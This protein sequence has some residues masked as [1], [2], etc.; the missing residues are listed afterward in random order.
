MTKSSEPLL[1]KPSR[2][3]TM[4]LAGKSEVRHRFSLN[5]GYYFFIAAARSSKD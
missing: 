2:N 3:L 4:L 5:R 1:V